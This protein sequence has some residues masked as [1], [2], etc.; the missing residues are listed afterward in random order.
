MIVN[1][2]EQITKEIE[3][4]QKKKEL[5]N[6]TT[7]FVQRN[8][9][10]SFISNEL[11]KVLN[12]IMLFREIGFNI[13][14]REKFKG[15]ISSFFTMKDNWEKD[16]NSI[17]TQ[18]QFTSRNNIKNI[19][20]EIFQDLFTMWKNFVDEK[21]PNL[22]FEQL[23]ILEKIPELETKVKELKDCLETI[24]RQKE[25][26][27]IKVEDFDLIL[28]ISNDM[29]QLWNQLSSEKI[30][31]EVL[32][33]LKKAGSYEGIKLSEINAN[34]LMWLSEHSLT[35]LCQVRFK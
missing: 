10:L 9:E 33:F 34:I 17:I 14:V 13:D 24:N 1:R 11:E 15:F 4:L 23:N 29:T 28:S 18:N 19:H 2:I 3:E 5:S 30:P 22:N 8:E 16:E 26:F 27:P 12:I 7:K 32:N 35:Q 25:T 6:Q 20:N 21:K 31:D